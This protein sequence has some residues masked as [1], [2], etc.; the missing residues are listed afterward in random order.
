VVVPTARSVNLLWCSAKKLIQQRKW[1]F[2]F[3]K[4][5]IHIT[6]KMQDDIKNTLKLISKSD[7]LVLLYQAWNWHIASVCNRGGDTSF[8]VFSRILFYIFLLFAFL[9]T[10]M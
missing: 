9:Y 3:K 7:K 4:N 2:K 5:A 8:F 6:A 1:F 10:N